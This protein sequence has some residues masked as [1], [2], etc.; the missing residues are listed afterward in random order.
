MLLLSRLTTS[1]VAERQR[2]ATALPEA[3]RRY[4]PWLASEVRLLVIDQQL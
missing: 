1:L 4:C 2:P 3:S